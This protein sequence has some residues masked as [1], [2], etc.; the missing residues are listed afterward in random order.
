MANEMKDLMKFFA[1]PGED[2][3]SVKE[4]NAF[5]KSLTPAEKEYYKTADLNN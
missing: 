5:W 2:K 3:V 4:F 1:R